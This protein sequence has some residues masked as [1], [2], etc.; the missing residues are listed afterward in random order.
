MRDYH[1]R[2]S[3]DPRLPVAWDSLRFRI[4]WQGSRLLVELDEERIRFTTVAGDD[5]VPVSVRGTE[6]VV[7]PGAP[8]EVVLPDQGERIDGLLGERPVVGGRRADGSTITAGVPEPI[9][10]PEELEAT[11]E[12][13]IAAMDAPPLGT[14]ISQS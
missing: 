14:H 13:P 12:I 5:A 2:L 1:G 4:C 3:F 9:H 11:G 7:A 10:P 6:Y 8:V